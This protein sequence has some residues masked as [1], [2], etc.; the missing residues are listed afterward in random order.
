MTERLH[1]LIARLAAELRPGEAEPE[2]EVDP[3][4]EQRQESDEPERPAARRDV[5][6]RDQT[7]PSV[8]SLLISSGA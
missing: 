4:G 2:R 5:A 8:R 1:L 6:L 3:K 7:A